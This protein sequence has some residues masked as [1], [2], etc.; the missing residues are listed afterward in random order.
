MA[1]WPAPNV[2]RPGC[3]TKDDDTEWAPAVALPMMNQKG[4]VT[5]TGSGS[6]IGDGQH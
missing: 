6:E 1:E 4:I 3:E 5:V 2:I